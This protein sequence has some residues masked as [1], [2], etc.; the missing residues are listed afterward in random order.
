MIMKKLFTSVALALT[1]MSAS[2][3]QYTCPLAV[4]ISGSADMGVGNV[5]VTVDKQADGKYTMDLSPWVR[6]VL[7]TSM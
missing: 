2:A 3:E 5:T 1:L 7:A 4:S 6:W